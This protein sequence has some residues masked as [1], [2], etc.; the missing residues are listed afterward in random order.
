MFT[1]KKDNDIYTF[2][3]I[4]KTTYEYVEMRHNKD[5]TTT[6]LAT[7]VACRVISELISNNYDIIK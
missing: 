4:K 2:K 3:R 5:N 1:L 7:S 6:P